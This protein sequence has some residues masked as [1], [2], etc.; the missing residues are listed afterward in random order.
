R[1][2]RGRRAHQVHVIEERAPERAVKEMIGKRIVPRFCGERQWGCV[3]MT[4]CQSEC[5]THNYE[6]IHQAAVYLR[7]LLIETVNEIARWCVA[8][9]ELFD[10][11]RRMGQSRG[12]VRV[13]CLR[14][15]G[16]WLTG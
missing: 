12:Q 5:V 2:D 11:E 6:P 14:Q 10:R 7:L 4:H 8:R 15:N 9:N 16:I 13:G 1:K 3:V